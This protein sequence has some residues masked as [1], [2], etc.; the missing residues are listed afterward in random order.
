MKY[1]IKEA[2]DGHGSSTFRVQKKILWR[3][4]NIDIRF[5]YKEPAE[6]RIRFIIKN[7]EKKIVKYHTVEQ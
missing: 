1:R 7:S 6:N 2:I 5:Y 3:W 4:W